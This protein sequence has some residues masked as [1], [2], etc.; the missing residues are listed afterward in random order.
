M[1]IGYPH[2]SQAIQSE[3]MSAFA[4]TQHM[5]GDLSSRSYLYVYLRDKEWLKVMLILK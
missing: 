2:L 4:H 5:Q 1:V 3:R